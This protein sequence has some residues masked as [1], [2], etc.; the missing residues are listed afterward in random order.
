MAGSVGEAWASLEIEF[1]EY[2]F[3]NRTDMKLISWDD[4][5]LLQYLQI[6]FM[7]GRR[8]GKEGIGAHL[9]IVEAHLSVEVMIHIK[10]NQS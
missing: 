10:T 7:G 9:P 1:T 2:N 3:C 4:I 5:Q 6:K 8:M